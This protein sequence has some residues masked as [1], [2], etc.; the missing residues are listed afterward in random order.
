MKL[1]NLLRRKPSQPAIPA[2]PL[3]DPRESAVL[4]ASANAIKQPVPTK[5]APSIRKPGKGRVVKE[6]KRPDYDPRLQGRIGGKVVK[7][8]P[9]Q[10]QRMQREQE[11][12]ENDD[13][14]KVE[15]LDD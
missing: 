4:Q 5:P 7:V 8:M 6:T 12:F 15:D 1:P 14:P 9:R 13:G 3:I 10:L 2:K 11:K